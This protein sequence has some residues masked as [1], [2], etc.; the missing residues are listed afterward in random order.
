MPDAVP[1]PA[2]PARRPRS[3]YGVGEEPE[4]QAS[5]ANER[6]ALSWIRTG[7]ALVAGGIALATLASFGDLPVVII[8]IAG[9]ASLGGGVLAVWALVSW[10]RVE[11]AL[12]RREPLPSPSALPW[13]VGGVVAVALFLAVFSGF[14]A[15]QAVP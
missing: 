12:R 4:V 8:A 6:T 9:L 14:E 2:D 3:V 7:M 5:L 10:R 13:L 15:L 1:A 11:R